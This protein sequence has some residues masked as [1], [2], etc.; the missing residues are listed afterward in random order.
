[1]KDFLGKE[2]AIGDIVV[3]TAPKYRHFTKA[4]VIAFT[5]QKVRVSYINNW[6]FSRGYEDTYLSEPDF[7]VKIE[8]KL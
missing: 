3:L 4:T 5:K 6:N 2:L 1:M 8:E 7:L